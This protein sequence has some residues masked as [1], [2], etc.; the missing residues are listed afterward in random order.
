M[1]KISLSLLESLVTFD[2]RYKITSVPFFTPDFNLLSCELDNFT[3]KELFY[4]DIILKQ[5]KFT[6]LSLLLLKNLN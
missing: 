1:Q 5:N 4:I 2:E 3:F 6:L